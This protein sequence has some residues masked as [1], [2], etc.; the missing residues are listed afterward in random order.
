MRWRLSLM[1]APVLHFCWRP[2]LKYSTGAAI[3]LSRHRIQI[4][5]VAGNIRAFR[6]VLPQ[7]AVGILIRAPL[8]R[9]MR[10][11]EEHG[12]VGFEGQRGVLGHL[13]ALVPGDRPEQARRHVR[14]GLD[15]AIADGGGVPAVRQRDRDE[16]A[17]HALHQCAHSGLPGL[18]DHQ[19]TL[20]VTGYFAAFGLLGAHRYRRH[21]DDPGALGPGPAPRL[22][23]GPA[24]PQR[25]LHLRQ[26]TLRQRVQP[27]VNRLV[28]HCHIR[29]PAVAL[30]TQPARDLLWRPGLPEI[31]GHAFPQFRIRIDFP[32]FRALPR[33]PGAGVGAVRPVCPPPAMPADLPRHHRRTPADRKGYVL[34]LHIRG[35]TTRDFLPVGQSEHFPAHASPDLLAH[36]PEPPTPGKTVLRSPITPVREDRLLHPI[37]KTGCDRARLLPQAQPSVPEGVYAASR[38][39]GSASC[40]E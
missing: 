7:Q 14:Q 25:D 13:R 31:A 23:A 36:S 15:D 39:Y 37:A 16:I 6:E 26:L 28:R 11:R 40:R 24:G 22:A 30:T 32:A 8:P 33:L 20:P 34:L 3:K 1:A 35:K 27:G 38:V 5:N 12:D 2:E 4:A 29:L 18:A 17:A 19:V 10:M 9:R 21:P